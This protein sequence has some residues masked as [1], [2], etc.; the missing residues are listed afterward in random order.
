MLVANQ[1]WKHKNHEVV[2]EALGLLHSRGITI[3]TVIT[4]LPLDY[5][6]P[7][8]GPT[9]ALLQSIARNGL[10]GIVVPLGLV[11]RD[12]FTQL[13]RCAA[14]VLQPSLFEGWG[15]SVQEAMAFGRPV[16]CSDIPVLHENGSDALGFFDPLDPQALATLLASVWADLPP[17]PDLER[18]RR[19]LEAHRVF[20]HA[21]GRLLWSISS[22]AALV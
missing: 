22:G 20:G 4:G 1:Y 9:S 14:V 7:Q 5:R 2:A 13:I 18:E 12:D 16:I 17:G 21:Q 10:A 11:S 3:P 6:D 8:N 15:L 19:S